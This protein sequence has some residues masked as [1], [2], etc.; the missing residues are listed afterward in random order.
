[1][2]LMA[3]CVEFIIFFNEH[4]DMDIL[5][6]W[7]IRYDESNNKTLPNINNIIDYSVIIF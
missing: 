1:M 7:K 3:H 6:S 5:L 2:M 4:H